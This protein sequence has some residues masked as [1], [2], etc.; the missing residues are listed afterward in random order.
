MSADCIIAAIAALLAQCGGPAVSEGVDEAALSA[1]VHVGLARVQSGRV[2]NT[3]PTL[4]PPLCRWSRRQS[5]L[6]LATAFTLRTHKALAVHL[7][8]GP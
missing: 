4:S 6:E 8:R 7:A 3:F 5:S 1:Q 2:R